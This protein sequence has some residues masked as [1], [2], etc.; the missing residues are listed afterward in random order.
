MPE[1]FILLEKTHQSMKTETC[2]KV[3]IA[4]R[5]CTHIYTGKAMGKTTASAALLKAKMLKVGMS[6]K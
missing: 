3:C 6:E 1:L 4:R 5:D 2:D